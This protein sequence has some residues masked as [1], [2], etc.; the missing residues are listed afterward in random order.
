MRLRPQDLRTASATFIA[1]VLASAAGIGGGSLLVPIFTLL[2]GFTEHEAIPLSKATIF[3]SS[4]V[5]L[6]VYML[7]RRHPLAPRRPLIDWQLAACLIPPMLLGVTVGVY[8]NK[9]T[10]NWLIMLLAA[11][12]CAVAGGR[13]LRQARAK[14]AA[15][16]GA[17]YEVV[18]QRPSEAARS[19][20]NA[21]AGDGGGAA[22]GVA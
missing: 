11:T 22:S 7:W 4:S 8:V 17:R 9:M 3:G 21:A 16:S 14:W 6:F 5:S 20:G 1:T 2:G 13:T 19:A 18:P 12:M 15:E 10:P